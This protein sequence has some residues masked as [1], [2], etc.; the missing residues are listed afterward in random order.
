MIVLVTF[1]IGLVCAAGLTFLGGLLTFAY[2]LFFWLRS[3]AWQS[4]RVTDFVSDSLLDYPT[5]WLGVLNVVQI[6]LQSPLSLV[7]VILSI[8]L[9]FLGLL[10]A[11]IGGR[12]L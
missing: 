9:F 11:N 2:E 12:N 7:L 10:V 1:G 3:G 8:P 5:D 6:G 4:I